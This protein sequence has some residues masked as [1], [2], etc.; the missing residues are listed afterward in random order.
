MA[1]ID[2]TGTTGGGA[3]TLDGL[4]VVDVGARPSAAWCARLI[5]DLGADVIGAEPAGGNPLRHDPPAAAYF[6]A[7]RRQTDLRSALSLAAE[8]DVILTSESSPETSV[9]A[10]RGL[11]GAAL[12]VCITAYGRGSRSRAPDTTRH[13]RPA[14]LPGRRSRPPCSVSRPAKCSTSPSVTCSAPPS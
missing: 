3:A 12:I 2:D 4:R 8:A 6:L 14:R 10:L 1:A 7:N 5:A 9:A 13:F 11:S